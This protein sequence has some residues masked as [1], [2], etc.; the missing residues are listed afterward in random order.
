MNKT[1]LT[2]LDKK[3]LKA[4]MLSNIWDKI[5][6][7]A[8]HCDYTKAYSM[9]LGQNCDDMYLTRLLLMTGPTCLSDMPIELSR[10]VLKR[11]N[12]V[13]RSNMVLQT[14]IDWLDDAK[15][16]G[17]FKGMSRPEQNEY[18][19]TMYQASKAEGNVSE[20]IRERASETYTSLKKQCVQL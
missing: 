7:S 1:E 15:R 20:K 3:L 5:A 14:Q 11:L 13:N 4:G 12:K 16:S 18:L 9:A 10:Q 2:P 19:D 17:L 8:L 6:T